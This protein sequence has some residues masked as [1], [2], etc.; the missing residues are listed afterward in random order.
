[1]A[2]EPRHLLNLEGCSNLSEL[3]LNM[4]RSDSCALRDSIYILSTLDLAQSSRLGKVVLEY[5]CDD[6]WFDKDGRWFNKDG[7]NGKGGE[8]GGNDWEGFDAVLSKLAK[9][10]ISTRGERLTFTLVV[11]RYGDGELI[12]TVRKGFPKMLPRFN[13]LGLLYVQLSSRW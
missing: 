1:M 4:E 12:S 7:Q 3:T 6:R 8:D 10:S 9:A 11:S 2:L 5:T 13:E